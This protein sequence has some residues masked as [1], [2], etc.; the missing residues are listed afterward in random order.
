VAY[1]WMGLIAG[2]AATPHCLG[3]CGAFPLHLSRAGGRGVR[4]VLF[5]AGKTVSYAF[6][7][8]LAGLLGQALFQSRAAA[9]WQNA[10]SYLI[11]AV[12]LVAGLAMLGIIPRMKTPAFADRMWAAVQP[13]YQ[14]LLRAPGPGAA[15]VLGVGVGFLPCP[16]TY[17][18]CAAA[19]ASH[20]VPLGM[21]LLAGLGLGT[22]PAMLGVG[23]SGAL[24]GAR[25]RRLGLR[26]VAIVVLALGLTTILRPTGLLCRLLSGQA[27]ATSTSASGRR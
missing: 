9:S 19:A 24:A 13:L 11:G 16:A 3:M 26:G 10:F 22:A 27:I 20:S 8:A 12:M 4:Q 1:L 2:L 14:A 15:L 17:A 23:L 21:A 7:G 5:L 18:L 6:L 25:L